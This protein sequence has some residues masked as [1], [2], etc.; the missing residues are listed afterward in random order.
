MNRHQ[1]W[2]GEYLISRENSFNLGSIDPGVSAMTIE[3][4]FDDVLV[5]PVL[6]YVCG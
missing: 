2:P 3:M 6:R 5:S 4:K 1:Y